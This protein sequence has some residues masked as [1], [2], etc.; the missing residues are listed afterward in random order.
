MRFLQGTISYGEIKRG[1]VGER[2]VKT[3]LWPILSTNSLQSA[4]MASN[5]GAAISKAS[6]TPGRLRLH[7]RQ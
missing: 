3:P 1:S 2:A 7:L 4:Q 5:F 6:K